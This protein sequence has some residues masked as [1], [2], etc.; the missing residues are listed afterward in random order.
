[1]VRAVQHH[2]FIGPTR[3][4]LQARCQIFLYGNKEFSCAAMH[5]FALQARCRIFLRGNQSFS[6]AERHTFACRGTGKPANVMV[7]RRALRIMLSARAAQA[8][9]A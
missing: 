2:R 7:D 8:R 9:T 6:P 1:V 5:A 4:F 3:D